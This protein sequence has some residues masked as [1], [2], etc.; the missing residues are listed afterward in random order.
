MSLKIDA[1]FPKTIEFTFER[2]TFHLFQSLNL[3]NEGTEPF[4]GLNLE[5]SCEPTYFEIERLPVKD[6]VGQSTVQIQDITVELM[7]NFFLKIPEPQNGKIQLR[8]IKDD[9]V[10]AERSE[11][12]ILIPPQPHLS[13]TYD[14]SINYAF[15][16]NA[17][18]VV[19]E[20]RLRNNGLPRKDLVLRVT[21]EPAFAPSTEIRLQAID[22]AG[23][24]QVSPLDLK[25]SH[26][27]LAE[28][29]EKVS[30]W[31]KVEML[32]EGGVVQSITEP[33]S[34][35][36]R[37]EWCGL[38]ALPEIL[39]AFVLPNDPA[40]MTILGRASDIL[41]EATGRSGL[42]G[43]QDKNRKHVWE[44][45]AA[46][47]KAIGELGIRYINPPASFES[48]GQKVRFPSEILNQRF[49][50]CLDLA[51]LFAACYEQAGLRPFV[52]MH[53]GH[54]YAGCWLEER[55]LPEPAGDDLQQV[56]KFADEQLLTVF[57]TTT[58]TNENPG[59][60]NDAELL[61][62]P[63]LKTEKPFRL[64]LDV[65]ASR[66]ARISPLPVPGQERMASGAAS[67]TLSAPSGGLGT[68]DFAD[69][70]V[71]AGEGAT[72]PTSRIDMWK[73]R[74]LDLSLRNR[75]LNF[76]ETKSTIRI[77]S[78]PEHVEDEL[79]SERELSLHPKPKLMSEE[80]PRNA[81]TYTKEQRADALKDHLRDE[82]RIGR[83]HTHLEEGEHA[84]RLTE[85]FRSARNAL[86][87]NGT[88]TLFAAVGILEWRETKHSDRVH[89]APL[90][91]VPVELKRKSV[92]EG[93]SLRR[94]DEETRLN[95]TLMEMLRQNFKKEI[96]GLDP[97]PEDENGVNVD[98]VFRIFRDAVR[99]LAGWEVKSEVWLGQFS[100]TKFLLWK[101]LADRLDDL[102][103]NR[104]VNHLIHEAGTPIPNPSED[105]HARDL[106][107]RF[108]PREIL[109]PRSADSSQ[110]AAVMAA[111]DGHDFVLEGPPGT[112]KSHTNIIAHCLAVGKRVLFVAEKRAALDVVHR[113]LR[114]DG[115]EPF[116]LELHSN[117]TGKAD[118]LAQ[119][120]RSLKFAEETNATDWE[121]RT[122][123]IERLRTALNT[124]TRVLHK[125]LPCGLSA[126]HCF[127]YLLAR[128][129]LPVVKMDGW[130]SI[131]E[132]KAETLEHARQ[133]ARLMQDRTR[134]ISPLEGH[135]LAPI[136]CEEWSPA[137]AERAIGL[138]VE[139]AEQTKK[140]IDATQD[141]LKWMQLDRPMSRRGLQQLD[142]LL[143]TLHSPE[144]V[145][146]AFATTPWAQL[147][148]DLETWITLTKERGGIRSGLAP[149]QLAQSSSSAMLAC[150]GGTK[151]AAEAMYRKARE[152][153]A[154]TKN[155]Q[156]AV[157]SMLSWLH[158]PIVHVSRD[159]LRN[160]AVLADRLL[161]TNEVGA[162]FATTPWQEWA[163]HFDDWISLVQERSALR[164]K[165]HG[166][167]E[168]KL[169]ALD[170]DLLKQKWDK[171]QSAWFLPK[172]L[173]TGSVKSHLKKALPEKTKPEEAAMGDIVVAA[174]RVREI[175]QELASIYAT[176]EA[177]LGKSWRSGEPDSAQMTKIRSW[178][179]NLHQQ[180][181][182]VAGDN[183]GWLSEIRNLLFDCFETGSSIFAKGTS[184]GDLLVTLRDAVQT[185]EATSVAFME[186][187][188]I[189]RSSLDAAND[190]LEAVFLMLDVFLKS[191]PRIREINS[192]LAAD[193]ATA[194]ACLGVLWSKGEPNADSLTQAKQ[195]GESLHSQL[196]ALAGEDF[197]WLGSFRQLLSGL[198]TEG[199][200]SYSPETVTGERM[201]TCRNQWSA[202]N[203]VLDRYTLELRLRR[204]LID[205][206]TDNYAVTLALT[207][208]VADAW[209]KIREWCSWQKI[210]QE[211]I[212]MG[213][214]PL[215]DNLESSEGA[216]IDVP[217]LFERSFRRALLF[218]IMERENSLREFFGNEH[219]ER[220]ERFRHLD[221]QLAK[222]SRDMI[223][224]RLAAGIPKESG[225]DNIPKAEIGLLRKEIVK[226]TRHIPVRQLIARIPTLLPRLKPCVLMSP[227][228]VAQ[229]LE[230]SHETFD[231]VIFDEASQ[232][233]VWDAI[234]AIARGRQLIIVGDPKQLPPTSF[235]A[236][237][238]DDED[239]LTPEEHKDLE[240]I[241]DELMTHGL[242]HKRL[243][244]H[245]RSRHEGLITF[246]N[247][248]YYDN[249]LLTFPSPEMEHGGVCFRHLADARYDKGKSR[250][251]RVEAA[252]LVQ[253]LV[254]RLRNP[255]LPRR[256]YGVVTFSQ[257]QQALVE[258][259]L[260]EER[261][262]FPE[263]EHHFGDDPP[264]EGEP[265]FVKNLENVQ[266]DERDVIFFSICYGLDEAGKLSMNFGPL[267][268]DGGERR[269]NVAVTRAKHEVL[270]F[271][272]LRGDQIDLT[273]TR[274][275]GVRDLK[276]FLEYAERG[277]LALIAATS[278]SHDAEADSEFERMVADRIRTAGYDVHYQVGCSGYRVDLGVV[279]PAAPGRYLLGVECDG[280]T[281]H[282]AATARDRDKLRQAVLEDLGWTIHRIW[283]TDW[284]HNA[285]S[286]VEKLLTAISAA[287]ETREMEMAA[288]DEQHPDS[289]EAM[290]E[291]G[292]SSASTL[293]TAPYTLTDFSDFADRI[294]ANRFYSADYE[295][296][297][298]ELIGHVL[299]TESPIAD[300]LLVNRIARAHGLQRSGRIITERVMEISKRYF[301]V[302]PDP[303]G[304]TFVWAD[305]EAPATWPTYRT[306]DSDENTR[307]LEEI[308]FEEIRAA[309]LVNSTGDIP[310]E[311][312]R[313]FGIRRLAADGRSRID[314]VMRVLSHLSQ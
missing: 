133:T 235:F 224:V 180:I 106:D 163:L 297:L 300:T 135:S 34:L 80:D 67:A 118:V 265:V 198:F 71:I 9:E 81:D 12:V 231:V 107:D 260:D 87:E 74:L 108:H 96:S 253:E 97:L 258:N 295:P 194:Q 70:I 225:D 276:H 278:S 228:S 44:Q 157:T 314:A 216:I 170:L 29:N 173:N 120:D 259:L 146:P 37:N 63:H 141:L 227:L 208:R 172:M 90:L 273:R 151:D 252:A 82:L 179:E 30:G 47:Y 269:L 255:R 20:L 236:S 26:D 32:E 93:F 78:E 94:I 13:L 88:N 304:G 129:D 284:W 175:N 165:L 249:G 247:R 24:F 177:L 283:S 114:E 267:N 21:T 124:Y 266:G 73:S 134:G 221:E 153:Q 105:I 212:R 190:H 54:A 238:T 69:E 50:T 62:K 130:E 287:V 101:D 59:N 293:Q 119:F 131:L 196:L 31:L 241:L 123:E 40:V 122:A 207:E 66:S 174:I 213:L 292:V 299:D 35:L 91:L 298:R 7:P 310:V 19:K 186:E 61:A 313:A 264:V 142:A 6:L 57:E 56:R 156:G 211:A 42:N 268:R 127:D 162:A 262:K 232:I 302:R 161:E 308:S 139:L 181:G 64:A 275:R 148:Q 23:E 251:N 274:A 99:E 240:S 286:E 307:K 126:Y 65:H 160:L 1:R 195:W 199:P 39:A 263:I 202:F 256:S 10:L 86:D 155:A 294:S 95:V 197:A 311:I 182:I 144:P 83:I 68:R 137:W 301:H 158:A 14:R 103:K 206:A 230:A 25:L 121:H 257:A 312:A 92:L 60:L 113:R 204:G 226:K 281:Y 149:Y 2:L 136:G 239:D 45:A 152:L 89:R 306:A 282:R 234:G 289:E 4:E 222:L 110:L 288:S 218:E 261:R 243:N 217:G 271:S 145:G 77:L 104:V 53:D 111:A 279:D 188:R 169:L 5:I 154:Y 41:K 11:D 132:T 75:L 112:G 28:L 55:S 201:V 33:I 233:P 115:L 17:I 84:R 290:L 189:D 147:S 72:K 52:F 15:Q 98:R 285:D 164:L 280:A 22:P 184:N 203:H 219:N 100:F 38:V 291:V 254:S 185:F 246:S 214:T 210:R 27:F 178:G 245:Y 102:T 229:Y 200:A 242:R 244:W 159:M 303:V 205:D 187:A 3:V 48:T 109:C 128:K 250:T 296:L 167:D 51:L 140:T 79:A 43:Y 150:E 85:L 183:T 309:A 248:Q 18:P 125:R 36:A 272:G 138:N 237:N 176:A 116:C 76:R 277:H 16:Q 192:S 168:T 117:K 215:V 270:V 223:R 209:S 193:A 220:I 143:E 46:I 49:G 191:V 8:L 58:V 166:Y 171:A 305:T